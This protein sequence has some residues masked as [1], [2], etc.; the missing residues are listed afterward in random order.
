MGYDEEMPLWSNLPGASGGSEGSIL[1]G[2]APHGDLL[3]HCREVNFAFS[4]D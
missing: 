3:Q 1:A 4:E 2:S